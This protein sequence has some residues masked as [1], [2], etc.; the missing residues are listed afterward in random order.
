MH[1]VNLLRIY[2]LPFFHPVFFVLLS[3]IL[4]LWNILTPQ[5]IVTV[6]SF[7]K[8]KLCWV[9]IYIY[10]N[11][12]C[13]WCLMSFGKCIILYVVCWDW[14]IL[15][16]IVPLRFINAISVHSFIMLYRIPLY[17]CSTVCIYIYLFKD[18]WV[19]PSFYWLW[20]KLL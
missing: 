13:L 16:S 7:F 9:L 14:S 15:P 17:R 4:L 8:N 6:Q 1:S 11:F 3:Y 2:L 18:V 10:L 12:S 19:F 5:H 20:I